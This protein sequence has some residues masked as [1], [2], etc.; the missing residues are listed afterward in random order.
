M[1]NNILFFI[2]FNVISNRRIIKRIIKRISYIFSHLKIKKKDYQDN[3]HIKFITSNQKF[4][5]LSDGQ[6]L[7]NISTFMKH[8][9]IVFLMLKQFI[10]IQI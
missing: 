2:Y 7:I 10:Q 4:Q 5:E 8:V 6:F 3:I 9:I 1:I